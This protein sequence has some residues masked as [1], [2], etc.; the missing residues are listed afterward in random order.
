[1]HLLCGALRF[2]LIALWG[3]VV[4]ILQFLCP[5]DIH[6]CLDS[7]QGGAG[8]SYAALSVPAHAFGGHVSFFLLDIHEGGELLLHGAHVWTP[9]V[10]MPVF[11]SGHR[12]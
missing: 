8:T 6:E 5:W 1:M 2:I 12:Q 10:N 3:S 7:F 4:T 11:Q 9:F